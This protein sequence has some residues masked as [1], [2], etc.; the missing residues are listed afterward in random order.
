MIKRTRRTKKSRKIMGGANVYFIIFKRDDDGTTIRPTL[1][2]TEDDA[3][4][5]IL[6]EME[7]VASSYED[8]QDVALEQKTQRKEKD[9]SKLAG[10]V[11]KGHFWYILEMSD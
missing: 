7:E 11:E 5:V 9:G 1:Y 6:K 8:E 10:Y 4:A 2:K 3:R